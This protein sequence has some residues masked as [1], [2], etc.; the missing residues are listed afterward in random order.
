MAENYLPANHVT[1]DVEN[2]QL[3]AA[4]SPAQPINN[5]AID[6][7][8]INEAIDA[9][10]RGERYLVNELKAKGVIFVKVPGFNRA[11]NKKHVKSLMESAKNVKG[12]LQPINVITA[13]EYFRLYPDRK[14][15]YGDKVFTKDSP[16]VSLILV[17]L[18][19]QHREQAESEL[20]AEP[21]YT[22]T[23]SVEYVDLHGL[24]PDQWMVETNTQ[25]RNWTSK[26]RTEYILS[27]NP[28]KE[29]N[30][31]LAREWQRKYGM[32]E[33]AAYA[34]L[35]LND[36]YT[37]SRQVD[38]M[39]NPNAGLPDILKGTPE[40][41]ERGKK[42]LLALEVGFR[43]APKMLKNM[44]AIKLA[45]EKYVAA[46]DSKKDKAVKEIILFFMTLEQSVAQK[47]E[48]VS[49]VDAKTKILSDEWIRI[50]KQF[51]TEL[52]IR[53]LEE[54]AAKAEEEWKT[55]QEK[56]AAEKV[57]AEKKAQA[58]A[59]K[60]SSKAKTQIEAVKSAN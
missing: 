22:A 8:G 20:M 47:A 27:V 33:R 2:Q 52:S 37:K 55:I 51:S 25:S 32:G 23:L 6:M 54:Q 11:V 59:N 21:D 16:E 12:F 49:G 39:N 60:K 5:Q 19:G 57:E 4:E 46:S 17:I 1:A 45:I 36:G 28:E 15:V 56:K 29:T 13:E 31:A 24:T 26:D 53:A 43:T 41:R 42:I 34:I 44:A 35:T 40:Q 50:S 48:G 14:I 7:N 58:R 38:Y 10:K 9:L 30:I 18:D 3:S